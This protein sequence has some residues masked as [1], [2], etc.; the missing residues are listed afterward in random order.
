[1]PLKDE[2]ASHKGSR[3]PLALA[4]AGMFCLRVPMRI[5]TAYNRF[6][7]TWNAGVD[8]HERWQNRPTRPMSRG[9]RLFLFTIIAVVLANDA[10]ASAGWHVLVPVVVASVMAAIPLALCERA[11]KRPDRISRRGSHVGPLALAAAIAALF[12][13]ASGLTAY[14][15]L[16]ATC[17]VMIIAWAINDAAAVLARRRLRRRERA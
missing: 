5:V 1:M 13:G 17:A 7:R 12:Y 6:A 15:T 3:T 4:A 14:G 10:R 11:G 9:R 2:R 16:A 8:A